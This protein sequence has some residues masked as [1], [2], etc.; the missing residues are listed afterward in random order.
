MALYETRY[1]P[2]AL[3]FD[4]TEEMAVGFRA[5]GAG[6]VITDAHLTIVAVNGAYA[7][8]AGLAP[9]TLCGTQLAASLVGAAPASTPLER[10]VTLRHRNGRSWP[11]WM[12]VDVLRDARGRV[13]RHVFTFTDI[14]ALK[15]EHELLRHQAR[16]DA[17]TGLPNRAVFEDELLRCMAHAQRH[18]RPMALL[19]ID[20]DHFKQVN[21]SLGHGVGD[22]LLRDFGLRLRRALRAEDVV[23][24]LGGDEFVAVLEDLASSD[25]AARATAGVLAAL[26]G[27][28]AIDGHTL[29][30]SAS[31]GIAMYPCDAGGAAELTKIA[32]GAMYRAK[33]QGGARFLFCSDD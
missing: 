11:A 22:Q 2:D 9:S 23:A 20:V 25:D 17:L 21:D 15:R 27:G 13:Q 32:D 7:E 30:L 12:R 5:A 1:L 16:H 6:I 8:A 31:I 18:A 14:T 26:S 10:E 4:E 28:F 3:A 24:R 33:H 29:H 19:F